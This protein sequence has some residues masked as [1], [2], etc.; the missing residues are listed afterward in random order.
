MHTKYLKPELLAPA[1]TMD[2]FRAALLAGADA[3]YIGLS[4]FNARRNAQNFTVEA[5][6]KACDMAHLA[7]RRVYLTANAV[8]LENELEDA[9][10]LIVSAWERGIDAVIVQDIGLMHRLSTEYPQVELHASTQ[11]NIHSKEGVLFAR[12][13]GASRAILA[14]ELSLDEIRELSGLGIETEVFIHGALCV[15]Y[16]GQCLMSSLIG[17][18]SANRGLC[19]QACRLP[20]EFRD[21]LGKEI[22]MPG[23]HLLSPKDLCTIDILP[24]LIEAGVSSLKIEGRMKSPAYVAVVVGTYRQALDRAYEAPE[25]YA[26]T[27]A[28]KTQLAEAFSRGFTTAYMEGERG[29]DMMSYTRPN[30]RGVQIGRITALE[31][32]LVEIA[33]DKTLVVGDTLEFWTSRGRFAQEVDS[34]LVDGRSVTR[35]EVKDRPRMIIRRPVAPGDRVFRVRNE[36]MSSAAEDLYSDVVGVPRAL[37]ITVDARIGSPLLVRVRDEQGRIG[38]AYGSL[39]EAA[40]TRAVS[41]EDIEEHVGRLGGTPYTV[42]SWDIRLDDGVGMGFSQLHQVRRQAVDAYESA[43]LAPW[44]NRVIDSTEKEHASKKP[45]TVRTSRPVEVA[46]MVSSPEVAAACRKAGASII[47]VPGLSLLGWADKEDC[48]PFLPTIAHDSE[49]DEILSLVRDR[50]GVVADNL[51]LIKIL[52]DKG[53]ELEAGPRLSALNPSAI[54]VLQDRGARRLWLSPELSLPQ[55]RDLA[56]TTSLPLTLTVIGRQEL[57]ITE[58]CELMS[59]GECAQTCKS[60][61]RRK[62]EYFLRDKKGFTF[63]FTID[64][65]GCGHIFNAIELDVVHAIPEFIEAGVSR[66]VVDATLLGAEDAAFRVARL[67]DACIN[68]EFASEKRANTTTGHLFRGIL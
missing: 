17:R 50:E 49:L 4:E 13:L 40:R 37:D 18:R 52:S 1:G 61:T 19:A 47:Y 48:I 46:A 44:K 6:E 33:C 28:E 15:S 3:V 54:A 62:T 38:E 35:A 24:E 25:D 29:N 58:H 57:M 11:M 45:R 42:A 5:L 56:L 27:P 26:A 16:S 9:I 22:Q 2:A 39:L 53:V 10:D 31:G 36:E 30:N 41:R 32:G 43:L 20:W 55:I 8:V 67:R 21:V 65:H 63:P 14:R 51:A 59:L 23:E 7:G 34:M 12:D 66:F 64:S 60:C 68:R